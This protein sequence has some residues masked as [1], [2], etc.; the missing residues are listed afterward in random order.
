MRSSCVK[1]PSSHRIVPIASHQRQIVAVAVVVVVDLA[2]PIL[3]VVGVVEEVAINAVEAVVLAEVTPRVV[4][5][6]LGN[7]VCVD[8]GI[9]VGGVGDVTP[10]DVVERVCHRLAVAE[11]V[12]SE[13]RIIDAAG[14][15][16]VHLR[17]AVDA[18]VKT[19]ES[20]CSGQD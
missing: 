7:G 16:I 20:K 9:F 13:N 8:P 14:V 17:D 3:G 6:G 15:G 11:D 19:T 18:F 4:S 10:T 5:D 1:G 12:V 2:E